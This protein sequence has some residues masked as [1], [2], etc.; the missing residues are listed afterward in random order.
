[1][2]VNEALR[3]EPPTARVRCHGE[4]DLDTVGAVLD[5]VDALLGAGYRDV[6]LDVD[7]LRFC[8]VVGLGALL[9]ARDRVRRAHGTLVLS[10]HRCPSLELLLQALGLSPQLEAMVAPSPR[11]RSGGARPGGSF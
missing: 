3:M 7:G 11:G 4:L 2:A 10:S 6:R 8:D 5:D 1:M 9:T